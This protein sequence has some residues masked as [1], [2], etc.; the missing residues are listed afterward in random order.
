MTYFDLIE[1]MTQLIQA[2]LLVM[3]A[4]Y[5]W[6][7]GIKMILEFNFHSNLI[8]MLTLIPF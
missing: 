3:R 2:A 1:R 5:G 6:Y 7:P 4:T 8:Q